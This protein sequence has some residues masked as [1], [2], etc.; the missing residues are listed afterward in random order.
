M[1]NKS[2]IY[3]PKSRNWQLLC[4]SYSILGLLFISF[5]ILNFLSMI[6]HNILI[7]PASAEVDSDILGSGPGRFNSIVA[8]DID[9]DGR[10][11]IVFGNYEGYV[12]VLEFRGDDFFEEW[13]SPDI[14]Q[15]VWGITVADFIGD[16]TKE[17]IVGNGDADIYIYDAK[18]HEKI[19][20]SG[21]LP[22]DQELVR[23]VH[24]LLV[25]D[26]GK[27]GKP[28]L[29]A[30][31]G[32]KTDNDL[33]TVFIFKENETKSGEI[34]LI[35][36]IGPYENRQ[37][38][39]GVGDVDKDDD[40]EIVVGSGV[41]TG[42]NPGEGYVRVFNLD[43]A[44]DPMT[45]EN[46]APAI[47]P[48]WKSKNLKGDCVALELEDFTGDGYPDIVV[49]NGYRYQAGWVRILTYDSEANDYIE[50]WKSPDKPD[51]GPKPY[52]LAVGDI[53]GDKNLEIVVGNQ[54]GYVYIYEQRG[55]AIEQ[56]WRSKLLGSDILGIDLD[57]V[58]NDGQIEIIASQGGYTGKGDYTSGYTEPHIY[59]IDGKTHK[60]EHTI[61]ETSLMDTVLIIIVL[62]LV[63]TLLIVLNF[64]ARFRKRLKELTPKPKS[65]STPMKPPPSTP[66]TPI[67]P[68]PL[69]KAQPPSPLQNK[70]QAQPIAIPKPKL[71]S[72][73]ISTPQP[74]PA[75]AKPA[76]PEQQPVINDPFPKSSPNEIKVQDPTPPSTPTK[77][78]Q[79][80]QEGK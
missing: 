18:T 28:Y 53:D 9:D 17:I 39:I 42:E 2:S 76:P 34:D 70:P 57:D 33:G 55:V 6:P 58:D 45:L 72:I 40:L 54:A 24:G 44:L 22:K 26:L 27:G 64:Y 36:K 37:R 77:L 60:I 12:T 43:E 3:I 13:R 78:I 21:K 49:G 67:S 51:I 16:S 68:P 80:A 48:E 61:G 8:D 1:K 79:N 5:T 46:D 19:W 14:G 30:G 4:K 32:Y 59:I 73:S 11:E 15:R 29:L 35:S 20:D 41:A 47:E 7:S 62:I 75:Q 23:D 10:H 69:G 66:P 31:T 63:I 74:K 50:Y 38:G 56:E 71:S 25:H 65:G 52:G